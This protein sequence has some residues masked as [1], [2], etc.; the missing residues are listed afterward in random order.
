VNLYGPGFQVK[1][2]LFPEIR[3]G[4]LICHHVQR[5]FS[6]TPIPGMYWGLPIAFALG[7]LIMDETRKLIVRR[8]PSVSDMSYV[9]YY[10][11]YA[12]HSNSL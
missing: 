12:N 3:Y 8:Y 6:T 7:I 9:S 2:G 5:V 4:K 11:Q 10:N 1:F